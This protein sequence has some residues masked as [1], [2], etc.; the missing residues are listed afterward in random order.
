MVLQLELDMIR[1]NLSDSACMADLADRLTSNLV[2][3]E[4]SWQELSTILRKCEQPTLALINL[5]EVYI[6]FPT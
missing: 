5:F 2:Q 1:A 4:I 6:L 3:L